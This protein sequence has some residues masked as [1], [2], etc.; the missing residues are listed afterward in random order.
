MIEIAESQDEN[1]CTRLIE[2]EE[3]NKVAGRIYLYTLFFEGAFQEMRVPCAQVVEDCGILNKLVRLLVASEMCFTEN[4]I[5]LTKDSKD[6]VTS[7]KTPKWLAPLL[8]L[9]DRLEKVAILTQRKQLMHK[10]TNRTW[11][12]FDL[13]TGKWQPYSAMNNRIINDA[14]WA[15]EPSVRISCTRRRY[16]IT[17]SCMTQVN[18]DSD[19]RRPITMGFKTMSSEDGSSTSTAPTTTITTTTTTATATAAAAADMKM[20]TEESSA[21]D[22]KRNAVVQGLDPHITPSI[23]R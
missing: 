5:T 18:E 3:A 4:K 23:V 6:G 2:C 13:S 17:F 10:V 22:E 21:V 20:E 15:G 7:A 16:M 8:L 19:N 11:M 9:I 12:W 1:A 14:Y